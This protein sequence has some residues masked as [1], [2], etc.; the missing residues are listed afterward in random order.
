[1]GKGSRCAPRVRECLGG[2]ESA[3]RLSVE[4]REMKRQEDA[5]QGP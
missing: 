2:A 3:R 5:E 4:H 1:V